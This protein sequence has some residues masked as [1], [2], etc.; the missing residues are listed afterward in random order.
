MEIPTPAK[1]KSSLF[2]DRQ[3]SSRPSELARSTKDLS[4]PAASVASKTWNASDLTDRLDK[5]HVGSWTSLS[6]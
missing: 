1:E 3:I 5:L 6:G 4:S 2:Y